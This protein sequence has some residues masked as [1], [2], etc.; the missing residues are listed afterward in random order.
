[1]KRWYRAVCDE[2][3]EAC[4]VLVSSPSVTA[5]YLTPWDSLIQGWLETHVN[6][7]LR[8]VHDDVDLDFLHNNGYRMVR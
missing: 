1:M 5:S 7:K 2:H 6:C 3:R 4:S 8:L